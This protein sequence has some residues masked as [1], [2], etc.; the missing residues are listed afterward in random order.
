MVALLGTLSNVWVGV[1]IMLHLQRQWRGQSRHHITP[2]VLQLLPGSNVSSVFCNKTLT[3][4]TLTNSLET[5]I[6]NHL[7]IDICSVQTAPF[8]DSSDSFLSFLDTLDNNL[9]CVCQ[10]ISRSQHCSE[11]Q[12]VMCILHCWT[13]LTFSPLSLF[14]SAHSRMW[15]LEVTWWH[16]HPWLTLS[17]NIYTWWHPACKEAMSNIIYTIYR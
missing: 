16:W 2:T 6:K 11:W 13:L 3:S 14:L 10:C 7:N 5:R 17:S 1:W 12:E 9:L 4:P 8:R 15:A